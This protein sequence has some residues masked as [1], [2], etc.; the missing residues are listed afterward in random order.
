M[1]FTQAHQLAGT[2]LGTSPCRSTLVRLSQFYG[3]KIEAELNQP[4][5]PTNTPTDTPT[6]SALPVYGM[7]DGL[8]LHV[9]GAWREIKL[10][11]IFGQAARQAST[12]EG[13]SGQISHSHYIARVGHCDEFWRW[14][15]AHLSVYEHLGRDLV[16]VSDGVAWLAQRQQ[17]D[18][19]EAT[20]ILDFYHVM[21]HLAVVSRAAIDGEKRRSIWLSQQAKRLLES[22]LDCLLA[23]LVLLKK[24]QSER[25]QVL[26]YLNENRYRMDYKTYQ[27]RGL[28]IGSG[29]IESANGA[30]VQQRL[31]RAGQ[32]WSSLGAQRILNLRCCWMSERWH[33]VESHFRSASYGMA[34]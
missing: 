4:D 17:R 30:V 29:A 33:L 28:C 18:F 7:A 1:P 16:L 3:A 8:M 25:D 19:G 23:D 34:A 22:E 10:G 12:S 26:I 13:R 20:A 2:L 27:S 24:G 11:R 6:D 31:K 32:R 15:K 5:T 9:D 21:Q 14:W